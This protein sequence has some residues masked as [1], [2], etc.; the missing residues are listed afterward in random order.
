MKTFLTIFFFFRSFN[1]SDRQTYTERSNLRNA[2]ST[3][4][5]A[6]LSLGDLKNEHLTFF[7]KI[8]NIFKKPSSMTVSPAPVTTKVYGNALRKLVMH[9][10]FGVPVFVIACISELGDPNV[11]GTLGL[12]RA[13]GNKLTIDEIKKKVRKVFR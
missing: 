8:K 12:Y 7:E 10:D 3:N 11:I 5:L 4:N 9:K 1:E 13:S 6:E 2:K